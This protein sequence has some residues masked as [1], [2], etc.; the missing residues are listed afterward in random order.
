MA[1]WPFGTKEKATLS[2]GQ[3]AALTSIVQKSKFEIIPLKGIQE[4]S[5]ALPAGATV[6]VT[7]SP[8]KGI[9]ATVEL[10]EWLT[11]T[12]RGYDVIP[13]L[14]SKLVRDR[15]HLGELLT[16]IRAAGMKKV[17]VV[18]GDGD[19]I[20][21]FKDG[22]DLV[23]AVAESGQ[24]LDE[25][26]VPA[27]PEGHSAIPNDALMRALKEKQP[28]AKTMATQMAF[29]PNEVGDWIVKVRQEGVRL[30]LYLGVPG[31]VELTKLM[32]IATQIGVADSARYLSKNTGLLGHIAAA[33]SFGPDAFLRSLAPVVEDPAMHVHG[34]HVFT[35]NQVDTTAAWQKRMLEE[36]AA[37]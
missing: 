12:G 31:V 4:K 27:Y 37:E 7:A 23:R 1:L 22:V 18:G 11:R 9:D 3:R 8:A 10:A 2:P 28:F 14:S 36:L 29:N 30:P 25:I 16:R 5:E 34:L 6:T 24:P 21:S 33:G 26:G 15:V 35:F 32:R 17:F 13:H 20:G 19:A